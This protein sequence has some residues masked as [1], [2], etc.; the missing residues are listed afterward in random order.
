MFLQAYLRVEQSVCIVSV[1]R[2]LVESVVAAA[3]VVHVRV[4]QSHGEDGA[5]QADNSQ[6]R[7]RRHFPQTTLS[8]QFAS[9]LASS[10]GEERHTTPGRREARNASRE[11]KQ[12]FL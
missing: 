3:R 2:S 10:V 8:V 1:G 12:A 9:S 6:C 11:Q 7:R 4:A 5:E